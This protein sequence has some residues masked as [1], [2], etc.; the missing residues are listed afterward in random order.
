[1]LTRVFTKLPSAKCCVRKVQVIKMSSVRDDLPPPTKVSDVLENFD[2]DACQVGI[3]VKAAC[4]SLSPA[5]WDYVKTAPMALGNKVMPTVQT[6]ALA[7]YRSGI[8]AR[9]TTYCA[10]S[11]MLSSLANLTKRLDKYMRRA[12]ITDADAQ[13]Y[14]DDAA[15]WTIAPAPAKDPSPV[16]VD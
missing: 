1:M 13:A 6:K 5:H 8:D 11:A 10:K 12:N 2:L 3:D 9:S 15:F 7:I 14:I 4:L 16:D